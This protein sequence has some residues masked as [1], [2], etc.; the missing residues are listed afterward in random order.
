M[1]LKYGVLTRIEIQDVRIAEIIKVLDCIE[2]GR[3]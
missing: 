3:I 2:Y 1:I